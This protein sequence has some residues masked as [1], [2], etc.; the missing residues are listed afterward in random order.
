MGAAL[1]DLCRG[2]NDDLYSLNEEHA[3][4]NMLEMAIAPIP[5]H[6]FK[7]PKVGDRDQ[8]TD[9]AIRKYMSPLR[10]MDV[11]K[12]YPPIPVRLKLK[13]FSPIHGDSQEPSV[14]V[15]NC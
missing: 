3:V 9:S 2:F 7:M 14:E 6:I 10:T 1:F 12:V 5:L 8:T 11:E 13:K 4:N 15:L